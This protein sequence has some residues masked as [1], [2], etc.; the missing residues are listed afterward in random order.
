MSSI[1]HRDVTWFCLAEGVGDPTT[2]LVVGVLLGFVAGCVVWIMSAGKQKSAGRRAAVQSPFA[3]A[4]T[5]HDV[6]LPN[7]TDE[8]IELRREPIRIRGQLTPKDVYRAQRLQREKPKMFI[9]VVA[10]IGLAFLMI[11]S[12]GSILKFPTRPRGYVLI[13]I[14][15]AIFLLA[16]IR[17]LRLQ[18]P[19]GMISCRFCMPKFLRR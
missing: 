2:G 13:S 6:T 19:I 15:L 7:Q 14:P 1:S 18:Y 17:W 9:K 3:A 10:I 8:A 4:R 16:L 5:A 12:L 11:G